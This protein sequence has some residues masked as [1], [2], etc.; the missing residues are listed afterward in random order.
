MKLKVEINLEE[1]INDLFYD[2][3]PEEGV[4]INLK[5][6]VQ[7]EIIHKSKQAV[8]SEIKKPILDEMNVRVKHLVKDAYSLEIENHVKEFVKSGKV[9]GR[10]SSDPE[11]SVKEW[12][13]SKFDGSIDSSKLNSIVKHAANDIS[14]E[15][16]DR[17]DLL[18][19]S[20]LVAKMNDQGLL[21]E[22]I[23]KTIM[24]NK[25]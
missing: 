14:A 8:L 25:K 16:R 20:Q 1:L 22:G 23:F 18:F 2:A 17:Y 3:D 5:E 7:D 4:D 9:K 6:I 24:E 13:K 11:M 10:Y 15:L 21:K 19:A 12:V